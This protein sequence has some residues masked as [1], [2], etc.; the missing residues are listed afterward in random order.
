MWCMARVDRSCANLGSES[1]VVG[2]FPN[3][4]RE[5]WDKDEFERERVDKKREQLVG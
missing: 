5:E 2:F 3:G 1:L 4:C